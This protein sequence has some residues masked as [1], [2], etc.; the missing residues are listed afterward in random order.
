M[1]DKIE[2]NDQFIKVKIDAMKD[3]FEF[4][5]YPF[6]CKVIPYITNTKNI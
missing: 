4:N 5:P 3:A 1:E 6:Q 2:D